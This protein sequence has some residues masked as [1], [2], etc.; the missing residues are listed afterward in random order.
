MHWSEKYVGKKYVDGQFD[1]A[2]LVRLVQKEIFGREVKLPTFRNHLEATGPISKFRLMAEQVAM[3]KD[4]VAVKTKWPQEG[5]G[6]LLITRGYLQHIGVYSRINERAWILH[7]SDGSGQVMFQ[8]A[9]DL[10][11]RGLIIEGYYKWL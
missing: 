1:C 7:A 6:V 8:R 9:K 11:L 2:E 4:D 5:D 10:V 3:C